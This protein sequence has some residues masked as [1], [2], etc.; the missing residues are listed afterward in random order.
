MTPTPGFHAYPGFYI[1][2]RVFRYTPDYTWPWEAR[3]GPTGPKKPD[4]A[5]PNATPGPGLG[6]VFE[7]EGRAGPGPDPSFLHFSEGRVGPARSPTGFYV[8]GP[9]SGPETQA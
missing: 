4:P 5:W 1:T 7:P 3:P 6:L 9:G 2:E 8:L